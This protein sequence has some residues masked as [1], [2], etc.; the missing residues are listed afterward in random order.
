MLDPIELLVKENQK[1]LSDKGRN[2]ATNIFDPK[3][4]AMA[5][6]YSQ[7]ISILVKAQLAEMKKVM[8]SYAK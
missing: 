5:M 1:Y 4:R 7:A 2:A 6:K 3:R 8:K